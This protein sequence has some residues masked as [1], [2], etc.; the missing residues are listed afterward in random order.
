MELTAQMSISEPL[1]E[2]LQRRIVAGRLDSLLV[3]HRDGKPTID[4][5]KAWAAA[6]KLAGL[7]GKRLLDCRNTAARNLIRSGTPERVGMQL[8][9]H[10]TR[11]VLTL[12]HRERE[13]PESRRRPT[14]SLLEVATERLDCRVVREGGMWPAMIRQGH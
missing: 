14:C 11:S 5:R 4:W 7:P 10:K 9:G 1:K 12:Q 3:F 8:T 2:V 6:C 13:R